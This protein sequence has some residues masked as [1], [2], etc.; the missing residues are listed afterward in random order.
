MI[1]GKCRFCANPG[2]KSIV[3]LGMSPLSN[4]FLKPAQ[5]TNM[6]PFF[7]LHLLVCDECYLVQLEA[8][9][10]PTAIFDSDYAYFSSFSEMWLKHAKCYVDKM[11]EQFGF[12]KESL[13]VEIA[14][15]DGYLLQY[16][17]AKGVP[18]LGIEP[19]GN[20]A[21]EAVK[22]GIPTEVA[23]FGAER[24]R[25]LAAQGR[26]ADLIIGNNVL[27][28]VPDINDFVAGI[29]LALKQDGIFTIEF[30]H[31]LRLI[32]DNLFDTIYHEHYSY[33]SFLT[34]EKIFRAHGLRLFDVEK[35]DTHGGSLRIF[36][37]HAEHPR[38]DAVESLD[39]LR[40]EELE[41]GLFSI[42]KLA[43]FGNRVEENKREAVSFL[44]EARRS[45]KR[46]VGYGAPAKA[47]TYLNYCGIRTD[48]IEYTVDISPHKQGKYIPGVHVPILPPDTVRETR[49]DFVVIFPWNIAAE[50]MDQMSYISDWGARFVTFI[51]KLRVLS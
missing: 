42:E 37:C 7:P 5:L 4:S 1:E 16:F 15:N 11:V 47:T 34:A 24:G 38:P 10:D 40:R 45:G 8:C 51:P 36:G 29:K 31:L 28:H 41:C 49:P 2:L 43:A 22:K 48:L 3:D 33:I 14:S 50:I 44:I 20:V 46:V 18:V 35:L 39:Q 30:P 19:A 13:V 23:F 12:G 6:E 26:Q 9:E 27:A 17:A 32:E 25:L 21:A